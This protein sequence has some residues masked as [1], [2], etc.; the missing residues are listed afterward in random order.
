VQPLD[1]DY[2]RHRA[3][4][5]RDRASAAPTEVIAAVHKRL[6]AGY[7][8]LIALHKKRV[9]RARTCTL[10][11]VRINTNPSVACLS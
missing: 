8:E 9:H 1:L 2:Y 11:L 7:E 10:C 5:E 6:A 3:I 4:V